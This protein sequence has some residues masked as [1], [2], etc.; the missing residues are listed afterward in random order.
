MSICV[1]QC[2]RSDGT[3]IAAIVEGENLR[4]IE[5]SKTLY[6]FANEA[7]KRREPLEALLRAGASEATLNY[8]EIYSGGA[9]WTLLPPFDHPGGP[10]HCLVTGTGLSH[11]KSADSRNAM[12][13]GAADTPLTDSMR[14]YQLGEA[15][16]RPAQGEIGTAPEWFWKG[17]GSILC[18]HGVPLTVPNYAEDGGDEAEIAGIYIVGNHGEVSRV[19]FAAA[20]EFSDHVL[21]SRNYLYLA[22]SKLRQCSLGPEIVVGGAF[23]D[24]SG[25]SSV[26]RRDS[27]IWSQEIR[28]GEANMVHYLA[29]LEHHHFKY[30]Q[31]RRDGD[32]HIH[33]F[34]TPGFSF[35]SG[36]KLQDGDTMS[37]RFNGF[38]KALCNPVQVDKTPQTPVKVR[39]L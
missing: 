36:L 33:C 24:I 38:G 1:V 6:G 39:Q 8:D 15:G 34:G 31:H 20:N 10:A 19:G 9:E 37:V 2:R 23:D 13:A 14:M 28:S 25:E 7:I 30:H 3:R 27:V 12:H 22:P 17:D 26:T 11:R 21:E 18:A 5:P 35:G 4:V 29:N 16:G 32:V